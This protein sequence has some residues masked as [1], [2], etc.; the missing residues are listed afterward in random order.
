MSEVS[1]TTPAT[2]APLPAASL[3]PWGMARLRPLAGASALAIM[4]M[5]AA[6]AAVALASALRHTPVTPDLLLAVAT[7]VLLPALH[8]RLYV[9]SAASPIERFR[10]RLL[11]AFLLPVIGVAV[12]ALASPAGAGW[13]ECL[14]LAIVAAF[15][16]PLSAAAEAALRAILVGRGQWGERVVVIGDPVTSAAVASELAANPQLGLRPLGTW[17]PSS[18]A[19]A[20]PS[21]G[22]GLAVLAIPPGAP[23]PAMASLPFRRVVVV[24]TGLDAVPGMAAIRHLGAWAGIEVSN[25]SAAALHLGGK[26]ALDLLVAV[27]ALVAA[28]PILA[29]AALAIR[30]SSPGPVIYRQQRV[31]WRGRP[32]GILKLRTM[33]LDADRR[34]ADLLRTDPAARAE[35]DTYVK[36]AH[37]PRILP[38]VGH[39]LRRFSIDELPQL[40]NVIRGDISLVGPRPFPA[41]HVE[42]FDPAFQRLRSSIRP[43]LTGLWQVT[44]RSGASLARQQ[45]IDTHYIRNWSLWLDLYIV[46]RTVPAVLFGRG[47]R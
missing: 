5:A 32:V 37:D 46:W 26:R 31:G 25:P 22:S 9:A 13:R 18:R 6:L 40:W 24:H 33:H 28:L 1:I 15:H 45:A 7:G 11:A 20:P 17:D 38:G 3:R 43:G 39:L 36:L 10:A 41:Y 16:L 12:L 19:D 4:D 29:A 23:V 30:L 34:L 2:H 42:K 14:L 8:A 44:D 35:W 27:P 21:H 47:A